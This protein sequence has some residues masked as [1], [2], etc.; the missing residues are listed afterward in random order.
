MYPS[1]DAKR[2]LVTLNNHEFAKNDNINDDSTAQEYK[3][4]PKLGANKLPNG[5]TQENGNK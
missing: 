2:F 1:M 5:K 3:S 4:G